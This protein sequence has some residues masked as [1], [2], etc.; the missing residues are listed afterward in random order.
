VN[1]RSDSISG[2]GGN[3]MAIM[4]TYVKWT[5]YTGRVLLNWF[6]LYTW[7]IPT[8]FDAYLG[9]ETELGN[10]MTT[11][12]ADAEAYARCSCTAKNYEILVLTNTTNNTRTFH[13]RK[14][15]A[16]S[17]ISIAVGAG[18]T[19]YFEDLVN[20]AGYTSADRYCSYTDHGGITAGA[21]ELAGISI[22]MDAGGGPA[23]GG[24]GS[25]GF[26]AGAARLL[27]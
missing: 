13:F 5:L 9:V 6:G 25:G 20:T 23:P 18:L 3:L 16:N 2:A 24:G 26:A 21:F 12:E 10:S 8:T 14:N 1:L 27:L 22:E 17:G 15:G 7:N 11:T 19:G 4:V